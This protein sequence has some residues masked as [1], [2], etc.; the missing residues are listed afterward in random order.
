MADRHPGSNGR[1]RDVAVGDDTN[2]TSSGGNGGISD[3]DEWLQLLSDRRRRYLLYCLRDDDVRKQ[4]TLARRV[5]ARLAHTSP[6]EVPERRSET[7]EAS[8]VHV[9]IPMLADAGVVSYDRRTG[10]I[11]FD[12]LPDGLEHLLD[13]CATLDES[14]GS[15]D[16]PGTS[17]RDR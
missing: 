9:D 13:A 7:V 2:A 17:A 5:A 10:T 1:D 15:G 6:E 11:R 8:L 12:D 16:L 3:P 14:R 4:G